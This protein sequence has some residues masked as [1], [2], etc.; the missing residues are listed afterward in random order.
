MQE[1]SGKGK[2]K[3]QRGKKKRI[4]RLSFKAKRKTLELKP[5]NSR[6]TRTKGAKGAKNLKEEDRKRKFMDFL[7]EQA[8]TLESPWRRLSR[9]SQK[10]RII[11]V[12][13]RFARKPEPKEASAR[14]PTGKRS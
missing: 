7:E 5:K 11:M 12:I 10:A 1:S 6:D 14:A 2:S 8:H 4:D 9:R 3:D 13:A